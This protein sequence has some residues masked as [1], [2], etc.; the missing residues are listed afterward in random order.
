MTTAYFGRRGPVPI[1]DTAVLVDTPVG[2]TCLWCDERIE[3]GDDG[4]VMGAVRASG[5][6]YVASVHHDCLVRQ[7]IGSFH[8]LRRE[9]YCYGVDEP[10]EPEPSLSPRQEATL[11]VQ[12]FHRMNAR[13][14]YP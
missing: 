1:Y 7:A 3:E 12:E 10:P 4:F 13:G 11:A 2:A 5:E 8:H 14:Q 9:C 6:P